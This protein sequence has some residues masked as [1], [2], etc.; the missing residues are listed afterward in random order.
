[1][2]KIQL[3]S[4]KEEPSEADETRSL[5]VT[6]SIRFL[7]QYA[8]TLL[9]GGLSLLLVCFIIGYF[10]SSRNKSFSSDLVVA[11]MDMKKVLEG[12]D[13]ENESMS[14]IKAIV[15]RNKS[16]HSHYDVILAQHLLGEKN[17]TEA[18]PYIDQV[19]SR[20]NLKQ[21]PFYHRF[22]KTSILIVDHKYQKALAEARHLGKDIEA[23][24]GFDKA[25][26]YG[27]TLYAYNLLRIALLEQALGEDLSEQKA[28]E[29]LVKYV[30]AKNKN[31]ASETN[32]F[33]DFKLGNLTLFDYIQEQQNLLTQARNQTLFEKIL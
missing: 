24:D 27:K 2:A 6:K 4:L 15:K 8:Y 17:I 11:K 5:F 14:R 31:T 33:D 19:W 7:I 13:L 1:M 28:W 21:F 30:A 20:T 29:D 26:D 32:I 18:S 12:K 9:M 22:A 3:S 25:L 16:L 10:L 23:V